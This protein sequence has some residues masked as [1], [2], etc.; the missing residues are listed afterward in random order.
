M[1]KHIPNVLTV[2][3]F[4]LT[5][6]FLYGWLQDEVAWH[7]IGTAAF[8]TGMITDTVD[9]IVARRMQ[10]ESETGAFLDPLADKVLV[11]AGFFT[12]L[13]TPEIEWNAWKPWIIVALILIVIREFGITILRSVLI[14]N[15]APLKTSYWG[16]SKTTVQMLTLVT[17]FVG[18]NALELAQVRFPFF[19]TVIGIG[20]MA[21]AALA[22]ISGGDYVRQITESKS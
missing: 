13:A 2:L 10:T 5:A 6:V 4:P 17:A 20:I 12:L 15:G 19:I 7:L 21:S 18:L 9:G 3:R 1:R 22:V 14:K 8:F 16:K 11:I